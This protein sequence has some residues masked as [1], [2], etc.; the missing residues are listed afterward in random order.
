M[1]ISGRELLWDVHLDVHRIACLFFFFFMFF[2]LSLEIGLHRDGLDVHRDGLDV[3]LDVHRDGLD[4]HMDVHRDGLDVHRDGLDV[5]RDGLW[6]R[7]SGF[8]T[9]KGAPRTLGEN[10]GVRANQ[11]HRLSSSSTTPLALPRPSGRI[12]LVSQHCC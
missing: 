12:A 7:K 2:L 5:H 10:L 8:W 9:C 11:F 6:G 4:V 3:H 1:L